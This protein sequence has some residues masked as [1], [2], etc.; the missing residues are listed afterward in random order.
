[1]CRSPFAETNIQMLFGKGVNSFEGRDLV[2]SHWANQVSKALQCS[3][4][5]EGLCVH[6]FYPMVILFREMPAI[7]FQ[8]LMLRVFIVLKHNVHYAFSGSLRN[9]LNTLGVMKH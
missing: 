2:L 4:A 3:P 7:S 8:S 1:M 9:A 5:L 6:I